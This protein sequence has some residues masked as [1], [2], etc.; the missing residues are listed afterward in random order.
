[1]AAEVMGEAEVVEAGEAEVVVDHSASPKI[2]GAVRAVPSGI[3][4][5]PSALSPQ[6]TMEGVITGIIGAGSM[7]TVITIGVGET[8]SAADTTGGTTP[9]ITH[10]TV[11]PA[12]PLPF[13]PNAWAFPASP[14]SE[15]TAGY[16]RRTTGIPLP[17]R[18]PGAQTVRPCPAAWFPPG[19]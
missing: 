19:R 5:N 18:L 14:I 4:D 7:A 16:F 2:S 15:T 13:R 8:T 11:I 17:V 1:V 3:P 6:V 10:P 12:G 9:I